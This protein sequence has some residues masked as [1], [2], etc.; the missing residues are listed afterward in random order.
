MVIYG[1]CLYEKAEHSQFFFVNTKIIL[2]IGALNVSNPVVMSC[3]LSCY[4]RVFLFRT[5]PSVICES[6]LWSL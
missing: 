4:N 1:T 6:C 3:L 2:R 5:G